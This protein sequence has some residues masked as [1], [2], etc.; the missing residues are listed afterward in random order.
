MKPI[1]AIKFGNPILRKKAKR[2]SLKK[3]GDPTFK[4]LIRRMFLAIQNIGVG[5]AAP[6]IGKSIQLAVIDIHSLPHRPK[7]KPIKRVL[8]NPKILSFSKKC[9]KDYEG[10]LSFSELRAAALRPLWVKVSYFDENG[11]QRIETHKGFAAKVFQHEIDHLNGVLFVDRVR[12][13][14]TIIT[15]REYLKWR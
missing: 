13:P 1:H 9:G 7:V 5:L 11:K 14:E 15:T 10:C 2:I 3:L 8:I 6:Q 4:K 12:D